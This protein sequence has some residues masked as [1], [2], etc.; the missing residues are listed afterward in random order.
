MAL[1]QSV[2]NAFERA[3]EAACV[4]E[5]IKRTHGP[6]SPELAKAEENYNNTMAFYYAEKQHA[7]E[8]ERRQWWEEE[9]TNQNNRLACRS[10][11]C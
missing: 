10:Y 1:P 5:L 4:V 9:C 11:D 3:I 7:M 6:G 8:E 2:E